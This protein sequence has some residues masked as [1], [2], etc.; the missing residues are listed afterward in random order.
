M[1]C[2]FRLGLL[3]LLVILYYVYTTLVRSGLPT[4]WPDII[5]ISIFI[6]AMCQGSG[7]RER[8]YLEKGSRHRE[9]FANIGR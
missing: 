2:L 7:H 6:A 1:G 9:G 3:L 5:A 8:F 4:P